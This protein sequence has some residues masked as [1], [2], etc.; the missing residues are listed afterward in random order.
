M[1]AAR[2]IT[3]LPD[4]LAKGLELVIVGT[5]AGRTSAERL[6]YTAGRGN[7]F[8]PRIRLRRS[9]GSA[10]AARQLAEPTDGHCVISPEIEGTQ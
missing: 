6:A 9:R 4:P 2:F 5:G 3:V 10:F 7:R 8:W 1:G